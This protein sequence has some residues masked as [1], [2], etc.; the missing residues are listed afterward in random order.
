MQSDPGDES[1]APGRRRFHRAPRE[2][3]PDIVLAEELCPFCYGGLLVSFKTGDR[4]CVSCNE[5]IF[6]SPDVHGVRVDP[7][8]GHDVW[9]WEPNDGG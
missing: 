9:P 7:T 8:K 6:S 2:R 3:D 1:D 5:V 4:Y